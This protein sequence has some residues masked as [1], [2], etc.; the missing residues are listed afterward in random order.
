ITE[1]ELSWWDEASAWI[2]TAASNTAQGVAGGASTSVEVLQGAVDTALNS[3]GSAAAAAGSTNAAAAAG[4]ALSGAAGGVACGV[5]QAQ[6]IWCERTGLCE[7]PE[8]ACPP[9]E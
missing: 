1:G 7:V 3:A 9:G 2:G 5:N 6:R 8:D 4:S